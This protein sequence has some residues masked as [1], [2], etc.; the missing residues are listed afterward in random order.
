MNYADKVVVV[1]GAAGNLG[2]AVVEAFLK[3]GAQVCALDHG[4]GRLVG[5]SSAVEPVGQLH[6]YEAV[7]VLDLQAYAQKNVPLNRVGSPEI[8]AEN[9]LHII[10]SDFTTG[11]FLRVD[12]GQYL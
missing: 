9:A 1:T 4:K 12:G 10:K 8:A 7:D 11:A 3:V 2:K 6:I 5:V